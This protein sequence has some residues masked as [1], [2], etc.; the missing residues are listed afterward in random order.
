MSL[1]WGSWVRAAPAWATEQGRRTRTSPWWTGTTTAVWGSTAAPEPTVEFS[2][3]TLDTRTCP[4]ACTASTR[5]LKVKWSS[6]YHRG[7][8]T[9]LVCVY[10][11]CVYACSLIVAAWS[12]THVRKLET[13][14]RLQ[15]QQR[16]LMMMMV[17]M[18][19]FLHDTDVRFLFLSQNRVKVCSRCQR[20]ICGGSCGFCPS[21]S[22]LCCSSPSQTAGEGS[23]NSG[24]WW[25]SSCLQSGS[26][27][28]HT[29]WCGWWL[30]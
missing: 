13:D 19:T 25:P 17:V 2:R 6:Q 5:F 14:L 23:G 27:A 15:R 12:R 8:G 24:S 7:P 30:L 28:S 11:L 3:T 22:S 9:V 16:M 4:S 18:K 21:P 10:F 26:Q 20:T 1:C 29:C